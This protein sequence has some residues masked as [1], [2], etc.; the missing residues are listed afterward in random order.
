MEKRLKREFPSFSKHLK[1]MVTNNLLGL[2]PR[3]PQS[4]S[5]AY[6]PEK[7]PAQ[8]IFFEILYKRFELVALDL[9][10]ILHIQEFYKYT[11]ISFDSD[12]L[13]EES[14]KVNSF[15]SPFDTVY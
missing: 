5:A 13:S 11:R 1:G 12:S 4:S 8:A 9:I 3:P 10:F 15:R 6:L 14:C 7:N 2:S